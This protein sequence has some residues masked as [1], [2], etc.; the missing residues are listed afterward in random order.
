[1]RSVNVMLAVEPAVRAY[2]LALVDSKVFHGRL[3][4]DI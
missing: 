3:P 4:L 1:M 2:F